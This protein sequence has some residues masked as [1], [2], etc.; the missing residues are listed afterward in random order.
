MN[1]V[2]LLCE[3]HLSSIFISPFMPLVS[4]PPDHGLVTKQ[5]S[6]KKKEK[7]CITVAFAANSDGTEKMF[8]VHIGKYKNPQCFKANPNKVKKLWYCNNKKL[9][10]TAV[11]FEESVQFIFSMPSVV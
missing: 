1:L 8:P 11:L 3:W 4:A 10:M 2:F 6:G 5:M 9:W 7:F